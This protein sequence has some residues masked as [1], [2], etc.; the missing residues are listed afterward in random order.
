MLGSAKVIVRNDNLSPVTIFVE[1]AAKPCHGSVCGRAE[2]CEVL[3]HRTRCSEERI[4]YRPS[5]TLS[6]PY[7]PV[8]VQGNLRGAE[9]KSN[10]WQGEG[11]LGFPRTAPFVFHERGLFYSSPLPPPFIGGTSATKKPLPPTGFSCV[12]PIVILIAPCGGT[13]PFRGTT[14]REQLFGP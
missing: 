5:K 4:S 7:S 3:A 14:F 2:V 6:V 9:W 11:M 1:A 10:A 8:R 12:L 13:K